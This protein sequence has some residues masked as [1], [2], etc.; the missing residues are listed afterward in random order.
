MSKIINKIKNLLDLST[1]DNPNESALALVKA[2][3]LMEKYGVTEA[4]LIISK[5]KESKSYAC[6]GRKPPIYLSLLGEGI[7]HLFEC[8]FYNLSRWDKEINGWVDEFVFVGFN[9]NQEI[10]SYAFDVLSL[11]LRKDRK[12]YMREI[13]GTG[14]VPQKADAYALG[15]SK[16]VFLKVRK[17]VPPKENQET[18]QGIIPI[19][20]I[21]NY[22]K[23]TVSGS[24]KAKPVTRSTAD[25]E[26]GFS[27]GDKVPL[28]KGM[29]YRDKL[30]INQ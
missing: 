14:N 19:D 1:S 8:S 16:A 24:L 20:M 9:P 13:K 7:S 10:C 3:E 12:K 6:R 4:D 28:N 30:M 21:T 25:E 17:L 2:K 29:D 27:D 22:I 5:I 15:W 23:N 11:Q 26:K 18:E